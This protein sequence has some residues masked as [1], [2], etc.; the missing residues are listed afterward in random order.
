MDALPDF[1]LSLSWNNGSVPPR[2]RTD[3]RITIGADGHGAI[4]RSEGYGT[5]GPSTTRAF[6][7]GADALRALAADLR[8]LGLFST[9]WQES[10]RHPVGGGT[11]ALTVTDG[12]ETASLPTFVVD[13]Q[14]E[15]RKA[16]VER[17]RRAIPDGP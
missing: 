10:E 7:L 15:A 6:A 13:A 17:V 5:G 11:S 9:D 4:T 16:I 3:T 14:R 1:A 12:G 2:Y 8:A